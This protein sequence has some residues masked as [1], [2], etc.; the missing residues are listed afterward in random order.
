MET[1]ALKFNPH[2]HNT[3]DLP[4]HTTN[5]QTY[6]HVTAFTQDFALIN[7]SLC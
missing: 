3:T 7:Q 4:H 2:T 5:N 1:A 6:T